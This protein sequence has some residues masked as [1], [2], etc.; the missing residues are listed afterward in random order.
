MAS[1]SKDN[2]Q[3]ILEVKIT[4]LKNTLDELDLKFSEVV[5]DLK[6]QIPKDLL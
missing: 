1:Q 5:T 3:F 6:N 4:E 2:V